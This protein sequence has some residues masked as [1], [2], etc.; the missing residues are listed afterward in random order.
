M[1]VFGAVV[2]VDAVEVVVG[3]VVVVVVVVFGVVDVVVVDPVEPVPVLP[4]PPPPPVVV[5]VVPVVAVPEA[6]VVPDPVPEPVP[7]PVPE[8][9]P[10][11]VPVP[12][13]EPVPD[14]TPVPVPVPDPVPAV[15]VVVVVG[16]VVVVEAVVVVVGGVVVVV[17]GV[18]V[19]VVGFVVVVEAVVVEVVVDVV[20]VGVVVVGTTT[21]GGGK[22]AM[23]LTWDAGPRSV[24]SNVFAL[25]DRFF[26]N[27]AAD[28][29]L[30]DAGIETFTVMLGVVSRIGL[31]STVTVAP[32]IPPI[33]ITLF[34][35][36]CA[37]AT[38]A[39]G[40]MAARA[41]SYDALSARCLIICNLANSIPPRNKTNTIGSMNA[42]STLCA[43]RR[44]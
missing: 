13:P 27:V 29:R 2:D 35:I 9:V 8:P 31:G 3:A 33:F 28:Q 6:K 18:V 23:A 44:R 5:V 37:S 21:G 10:E 20:V 17:V 7:D 34:A 32:V 11:P 14:P 30:F 16:F 4:P 19:V 15:V 26:E 43:P 39:P 12:V 41:A 36:A 38:V 24:T 42:I 40:T 1:V 22:L 25:I